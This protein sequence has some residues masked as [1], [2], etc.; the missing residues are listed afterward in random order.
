MDDYCVMV[1]GASSGLGEAFARALAPRVRRLVLVARR[2]DRLVQLRAELVAAHANLE[3]VRV[4]R[5]DL[6]DP[7]DREQLARRECGEIDL[8]VNNAGLGDYGDFA[9]SE[10]GRVQAMLEVNMMALTRLAHAV[11]PGM[12]RRRRGGVIHVSS[13]AGELFMPDFAVYAATK[14]YVTR[15]SEALRLEVREHGVKV[16][17]VCPGPVATEFGSVARRGGRERSELPLYRFLYVRPERVVAE[18]LAAFDDGRARVFPGWPVRL[19]AAGIGVLPGWA[20]RLLLGRRPR[21]TSAATPD[22]AK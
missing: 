4:C 10:W 19:V 5:A 2:E 1:T 21:R 14:A 16:V 18:A 22:S 6:A 7:A 13:L 8:L 17:A 15:F 12:R 3:E 9:G 11:V 20:E